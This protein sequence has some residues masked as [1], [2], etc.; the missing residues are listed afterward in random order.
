MEQ[1][2]KRSRTP[3]RLKVISKVIALT[4]ELARPQVDTVGIEFHEQDV[5]S[6]RVGVVVQ[7]AMRGACHPG[8]ANCVHLCKD[9]QLS[10]AVLHRCAWN[11]KEIQETRTDR[12]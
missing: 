3:I 2:R 12:R 10:F 8:I 5:N 4:T 6:T 9:R 1:I 11:L 7:G